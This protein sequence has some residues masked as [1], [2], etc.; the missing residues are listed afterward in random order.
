[1]KNETPS[2]RGAA[3]PRARNLY[4]RGLCSWIPDL[5]F[6]EPG[7]THNLCA[8]VAGAALQ[9]A[10][11][12]QHAHRIAHRRDGV[13]ELRLTMR[14]RDDPAEVARQI[15]AMHHHREAHLVHDDG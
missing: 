10:F 1:P 12:F 4:S 14:R 15:D 5:A 7:M 6:G 2:F 8:R 3:R 9:L 13:F 11:G